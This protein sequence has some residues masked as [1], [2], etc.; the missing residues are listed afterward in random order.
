[1]GFGTTFP[2]QLC[3]QAGYRRENIWIIFL[4]EIKDQQHLKWNH[5]CTGKATQGKE[6]RETYHRCMNYPSCA[7]VVC[8]PRPPM[9]RSD[10]CTTRPGFDTG[11]SCHKA[12]FGMDMTRTPGVLQASTIPGWTL[13]ISQGHARTK[14]KMLQER[15]KLN[16]SNY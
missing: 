6:R 16:C 7:S 11:P 9:S 4:V 1:M 3:N 14:N 12:V 5:K 8:T 10:C 2:Q 15:K 13:D